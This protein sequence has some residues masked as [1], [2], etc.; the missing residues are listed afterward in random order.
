MAAT[1]AAITWQIPGD[2]KIQGVIISPALEASKTHVSL[3]SIALPYLGEAN[4][5]LYVPEIDDA[6]KEGD[7][8]GFHMNGRI[9]ALD[10]SEVEV[11][12]AE[13]PTVLYQDVKRPPIKAT[14]HWVADVLGLLGA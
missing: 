12:F 3:S 2:V 7:G 9:L 10:R 8:W 5:N 14:W 11:K 13:A 6:Y 1:I 4:G